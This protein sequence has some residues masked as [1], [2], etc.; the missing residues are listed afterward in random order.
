[1]LT[2]S[3]ISKLKEVF[4]TKDD[5]KDM[6]NNIISFKDEILSEII[7]LRNDID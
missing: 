5:F 1:M 2:K 3:D 7:K 4:V 6:Q